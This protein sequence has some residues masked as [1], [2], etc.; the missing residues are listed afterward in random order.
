MTKSSSFLKHSCKPE[1]VECFRAIIYS[2]GLYWG[3]KVMALAL[4]DMP[5]STKTPYAKLARKFH[6]S[7]SQISRWKA[8]LAA[9]KVYIFDPNEPVL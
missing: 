5:K 8:Q 7:P 6:V 3:A 4:L 9:A 2:R 1:F